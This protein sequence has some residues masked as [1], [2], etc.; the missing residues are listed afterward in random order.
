[1]KRVC[2]GIHLYAEPE[3]LQATLAALQASTG[4][5]YELLLLLDG[6]DEPTRA[7]M[8]T[9]G[10]LPQSGTA[11]PRGAAACFNR[12]ATVSDAD[13]LVMLESGALVGP[14]WLAHIL[15]ALDADLRN[16]LAGPSTNRSWNEQGV[17]PQSGASP[18]A[19]ARTAQEAA[20]RFGNEA[21]TLE[22]LY[23]LADFCYVVQREVIETIGAADENY[24][25]GPCWEMDYNVRAARAGWRGVWAGAAYVHRSPFTARRRS[26]EARRLETSKHIYQDRFCGARLRGL[27]SDYR[28]H[29]R[30]DACPNFAPP[31]LITIR[32]AL[33]PQASDADRSARPATSIA[34]PLVSC[35][36]PTSNRRSF[37]TQSIRCFLRQDYP[38]LELVIIDDGSDPVADCVPDDARIRYL[39]LD[40]KLTIGAKRNVGCDQARGEFIVHWDDDDWY[41][42]WRVR[43]QLRALLDRPADVCGTSRISYYDAGADRAW[44][45]RYGVPGSGWV[46]GNTLAYRRTVWAQN[47]FRDITIGED[48]LFVLNNPGKMVCDLMEPALCIA[49]IH[50]GNTSAKDTGTA[51]WHPR[52]STDIRALLGDDR[53][54]YC[55]P[56]TPPHGRNW[57][58]VSCIM[59]TYN[60]RPFVRLALQHFLGQDYPNKELVIVDDSDDPIGDVAC[61]R[62]GVRY[63]HQPARTSI[64]AKRNLA[65]LHARGEIIAH[66]DDDDWYA[67][68]RLRYQVAPILAG[69]AD[70]TGLENAFVLS[71]PQGEFWTTEPQ[72]HERMFVGN[73]HGGTL[74]YRKQMLGQGLRYPE[75]NLAEDAWLLQS[76][77]S[78]GL[79]LLRLSNPG[80][81]VYVRH[82]SNAWR[83]FAPGRFLSPAGW[84][85]IAPP[86]SIPASSLTSYRNLNSSPDLPLP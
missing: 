16:G 82:Q 34:H 32:Q 26:E 68:D 53:Y 77:V 51:F 11:E 71:L 62:Q 64:G 45:Y 70:I 36:M 6:P 14:G 75:T 18:D 21:R 63:I 17:Y 5:A 42:P 27:K 41:P 61:D 38:N 78:R 56:H 58:L 59:P 72:L 24:A 86:A 1:M 60:R 84:K 57:P 22:P 2:I 49:M 3:R 4:S 43:V 76:A 37:V 54:L 69:D 65:C 81:F 85:R 29:C 48:T 23:S 25:L 7:Q 8:A 66:W 35:I 79:R 15:A 80:V 28:S 39:R 31:E 46:A 73:V 47:H 74:V 30:G 55:S 10:D 13:I 33:Q 20:L 19:I 40:Q 67:A 50:S 44:E 52:P 9:L 83:E 12:L